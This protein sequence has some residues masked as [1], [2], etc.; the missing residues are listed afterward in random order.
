MAPPAIDQL[1]F[2]R[3][4]DAYRPAGGNPPSKCSVCKKS[5][6]D[7]QGA[8][9]IGNFPCAH[10]GTCTDPRC[11]STYYGTTN[12]WATPYKGK[13]R[14]CCRAADC[15]KDIKGWCLVKAM[16]GNSGGEMLLIPIPQEN[17]EGKTKE[18]MLGEQMKPEDPMTAD[19]KKD[20]ESSSNNGTASNICGRLGACCRL[21]DT[22]TWEDDPGCRGCLWAWK[23]VVFCPVVCPVMFIRRHC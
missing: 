8:E 10:L 16:M 1:P 13:Q 12:Q 6:L 23:F 17:P 22:S 20:E 18:R 15:G 4:F 2:A 5:L 3:Y 19:P 21:P 11:I 14:L 7:Q 9:G